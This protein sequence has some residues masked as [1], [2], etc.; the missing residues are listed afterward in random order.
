MWWMLLILITLPVMAQEDV[1]EENFDEVDLQTLQSLEDELPTADSISPLYAPRP[2]KLESPVVH[3]EE[4]TY[5]KLGKGNI[6]CKSTV[7][8]YNTIL[9]AK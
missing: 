6:L 4:K 8:K 1:P 3:I 2:N 5:A 9:R 7:N